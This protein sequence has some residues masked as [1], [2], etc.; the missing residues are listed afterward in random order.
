MTIFRARPLATALAALLL[1]PALAFADAPKKKPVHGKH[2]ASR[3]WKGYG[4]I[5]GYLPADIASGA[6]KIRRLR[7]PPPGYRPPYNYRGPYQE[8][9]GFGP[10]WDRYW[11]RGRT[12]WS[13]GGPG[14]YRGQYNGGG[15]GPCY[16]QTP[17]GP[18]WN[19]GK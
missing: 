15:L 12:M 18:V 1:V 6:V 14:F 5:P 17:I 4:F 19:C 10:Y 3:H 2:K 13:F 9:V 16:T 7:R 11:Y 8:Y